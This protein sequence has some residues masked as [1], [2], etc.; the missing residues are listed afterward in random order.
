MPP[1]EREL[2]P[3]VLHVLDHR[4]GAARPASSSARSA[5]TGEPDLGINDFADTPIA[6]T[7]IGGG[8]RDRS[9]TAR[10]VD[11]LFLAKLRKKH[12][13]YLDPFTGSLLVDPVKAADGYTYEREHIERY[14]KQAKE[15]GRAVES[16]KTREAMS[17]ALTPNTALKAK[18]EEARKQHMRSMDATGGEVSLGRGASSK[19]LS[20]T[21][22]PPAKLRRVDEL[23]EVFREL[24]A[25]L[26]FAEL[27]GEYAD[28]VVC[29]A[30][31]GVERQVDAAR[32]L[33][34]LSMFPRGEGI[35]TRMAIKVEL[36][37]TPRRHPPELQVVDLQT[38]QP[39]G[40]KTLVTL[41]TDAYVAKRCRRRLGRAQAARGRLADADA[42][43]R[44]SAPNVLRS[45]S[46]TCRDSSALQKRASRTICR[47]KQRSCSVHS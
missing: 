24:D 29:R 25:L 31:L 26:D 32:A 45:T 20:K 19:K 10:L 43:L 5:S 11:E 44:L 46:L 14:I 42:V 12:P 47:S 27:D 37:R 21:K 39:K 30:R 41:D 16:P 40:P 9:D 15:G 36:R 22:A 1:R 2:L 4:R 13:E 17:D 6:P 28:A 18:I 34:M 33:S 38:E 3:A 35:R 7:T 8:G 23:G